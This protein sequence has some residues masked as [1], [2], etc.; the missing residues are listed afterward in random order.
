ML[1]RE[2]VQ[3]AQSFVGGAVDWCSELVGGMG[4]TRRKLEN[5][6]RP[7]W[8]ASLDVA[9]AYCD[10]E[11]GAG[12]QCFDRIEEKRYTGWRRD[13][14]QSVISTSEFISERPPALFDLMNSR[15]LDILLARMESRKRTLT[16]TRRRDAHA[17][18]EIDRAM[19]ILRAGTGYGMTWSEQVAAFF[20]LE[21]AKFLAKFLKRCRP[22]PKPSGE[23][24]N[25]LDL[26][27]HQWTK[28]GTVVKGSFKTV[29]DLYQNV[30]K[31]KFKELLLKDKTGDEGKELDKLGRGPT[32]A[33]GSG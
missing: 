6:M 8:F 19:K 20:E 10:Q 4:N 29:D 9:Q 16:G 25:P 31:P 1:T 26:P 3:I 11:W 13:S 24:W 2:R 33:A 27:E 32:W 5:K 23:S 12:V 28:L 14:S 15:N 21:N 17:R 30:L 18:D 7:S 22:A